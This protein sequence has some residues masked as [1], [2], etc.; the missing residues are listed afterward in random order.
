MAIGNPIKDKN[1]DDSDKENHDNNHSNKSNH[2]YSEP[3][4]YAFNGKVVI[5]IGVIMAIAAITT[6]FMATYS[7]SPQIHLSMIS[8]IPSFLTSSFESHPNKSQV[9]AI[10]P[11][12]PSSFPVSSQKINKSIIL[13]QQD[14]GWNG[15]NGGPTILLNKGDLVQV[16]VINRGHMAHNFGIGVLSQQVMELIDKEKNIPIDQRIVQI[17]YNT[18]AAM[19]CPGCQT[20]FKKGHIELFIEPGTQQVST[21]VADKVGHYKYFCMVRGHLWLGMIGDLIVRDSTG[22]TTSKNTISTAL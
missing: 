8:L 15:T 17:P 19:P 5:G 7:Q 16:V 20:D 9:A 12:F 4:S 6:I 10:S 11:S 18:M 2:V 14:F 1:D 22:S 3:K 21:F 13:I